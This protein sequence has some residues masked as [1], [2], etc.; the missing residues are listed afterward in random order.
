MRGLF[1]RILL[2]FWMAGLLF[3]APAFSIKEASHQIIVKFKPGMV[4]LPR[5][6]QAVGVG[7]ARVKTSSLR[8][9]NQKHG[10]YKVEQL[11]K[12]IL[13]I[14]PDMKELENEYILTFSPTI[15]AETAAQDFRKDPN[16]KEA[17]TN[18]TFRAFTVTPNDPYFSQ[19]YALTNMKLPQAWDRT[20]GTSD[21]VVAVLD[22]GV[23]YLHEDLQ[24]K[25]DVS[26]GYDFVNDDPDPMDDHPSVHGT[27]V[28]GLIAAASNNAKGIAGVNWYAKILP[29]KVLDAGGEGTM[30]DILNGIEWARAK[31]ANVINMSFGQYSSDVSLQEHC[32]NAYNDGIV[33]VAAAGNGGVNWPTY[34]AY[35]S[36]VLAVAA[37][38]SSDKRS[39]WIGI[40][41]LTLQ[42][43]ASNYGD[44]VDVAAPGT[45]VTSTYKGADSYSNN[46][47]TS[48]S[49][50]LVAG[51]AALIKSA[52]PAFTNRQ[53]MDR[54]TSE[55]DNID[56]LNPGFEKKLGGG[57][58][59]AY[60]AVASVIGKITSPA[61]GSYLK[62]TV[63]VSGSAAG[64]D[65][66]CYTLEAIDA[67]GSLAATI[68]TLTA[69]VE[70]GI[71]GK[72]NSSGFNGR[73]TLRLKVFTNSSETMSAETV[74]YIDNTTPEAQVTSF[75]SGATLEGS[76][77]IKGTASAFYLDKYVLD[78]QSINNPAI[79]GVIKT[80][81]LSTSAGTLGTWETAGLEGPYRVR[82][83]TYSRVGISQVVTYEVN[84]L[85]SSPEKKAVSF[86]A[87]A[88]PNPA[89][90]EVSFRY[91]L[92]GNFNTKI[93]IYDIV[94]NLV[95]Q[96]SY[97]AGE[98]GAKSGENA[99]V[100]DRQ[101]ILSNTNAIN[102][103]YLF[104]IV[105]DQKS[106]AKGKLIVIN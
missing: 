39:V 93:Y 10:V 68:E 21:V 66:T 58:A 38:D 85:P 101:S 73:Y 81:Y 53:I 5:G 7:E 24:A 20:T 96:K 17:S 19:Q 64:W 55:A 15:D 4:T 16:V 45:A 51:L 77:L 40:D 69:S 90:G 47:G 59:N 2:V 57:R 9:L 23:N 87:L 71:L 52:Y 11:F 50:P 12:K 8:A 34:P 32:Q 92:T 54:I 72:W 3:P 76:V 88:A 22:T 37:V 74:V 78:Y 82:L 48:F 80:G 98:N 1:S 13:E 75:S 99:P 62:G 18:K 35:L 86:T 6:V 36:T 94:G 106:V 95:W 28:S 100:W 97:L 14:R 65:F 29:I 27:C 46:N 41:L 25:V 44:W 61:T 31:H 84:V 103:V 42:T 105:S 104:M 26:N 102:G 70:G 63:E 83:I 30:A 56:A 91:S 89:T 67:S 43:Q 60:L 79:T 33:L 49:S